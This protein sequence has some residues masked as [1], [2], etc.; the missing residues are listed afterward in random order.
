MSQPAEH[1]AARRSA[2]YRMANALFGVG[3]LF[4]SDH[5]PARNGL[6][7]LGNCMTL[8]GNFSVVP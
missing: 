3:R 2:T 5:S 1:S 8:C 7:V 6:P 4:M